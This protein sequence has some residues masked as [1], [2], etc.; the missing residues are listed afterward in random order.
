MDDL[1]RRDRDCFSDLECFQASG[2]RA[3][4]QARPVR[5][6]VC[7]AAQQ[8]GAAL[9]ARALKYLRICQYEIGWCDSVENLARSK[10]GHFVVPLAD[11]AQAGRRR[12]P[13]AFNRQEAMGVD[14]EGEALPAR[15][16]SEEHTSELQSRPHLVCRLLLEK[17]H[18][19]LLVLLIEILVDSYPSS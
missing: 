3:D 12:F 9:G 18:T 14:I 1:A 5:N 15:R 17:K 16:R 11:A 13:P 7:V 2:W 19:R 4:P 10:I 6:P 8:I